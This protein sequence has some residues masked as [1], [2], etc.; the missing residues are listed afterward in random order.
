[1]T[2]IGIVSVAHMHTHSYAVCLAARDDASLAGVWDDDTARGQAFAERFGVP[3]VADLDDLLAKVDAVMIGS[4]N[5]KHA[6][7]LEVAARAG[8]PALCEKPLVASREDEA[9][10]RALLDGGAWIMT[11]FPCPYAPAFRQALAAVKSGQI[12]KIVGIA[13]TNRGSNPGGWFVE[14]TL[15]GGGALMDHTVHVADL[16]RRL[17]EQEPSSV[18]AQAGTRMTDIP[19]DDTAMLSLEYSDGSFA[20]LD[21]S[22]SRPK[23][24]MIWGD[25]TLRITGEQGVLEVDLFNPGVDVYGADGLRRRSTGSNLDALL[26][27]EFLGAIREGRPPM[28]SGEDGLAASR[29][30]L[31]GYESFASTAG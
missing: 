28:T 18:S 27:D 12:G 31:A 30:A 8:K 5:L 16:F 25:V 20:T 26:V 6:D 10:V 11:A 15:S 29:V 7:H 19:T 3:F 23:G 14:P 22:W 13:G 9:R 2:R 4:E 1:M 24:Y 17:L 21:A